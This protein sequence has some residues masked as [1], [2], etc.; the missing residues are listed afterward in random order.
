MELRNTYVLQG[1]AGFARGELDNVAVADDAVTLER[2]GG[3][4]VLYGCYTSPPVN[5]PGFNQM[6]VSWNADTPAGTVVEAQARVLQNGEWSG[7]ASFGKWSP[8][9]RRAGV[10]QGRGEAGG[11]PAV[12][13]DLLT[14]QG[15]AATQVQLRVYLY[16]DDEK[17]TPAVWLLAASV[18]PAGWQPQAGR[19][20]DRALYAPA[21]SQITRDP[22][23]GPSMDLPVA[24]ASLMNRWG[25]DVLPEE[26]AHMMYDEA[27]GSC[28]NRAFAAAAAG[29][30]GFEAYTAYM[31]LAALRQEVRAGHSA[32]IQLA[33]AHTPQLAEE[34]GLPLLHG[35][36]GT[37]R[38]MAV[39]R[40]FALAPGGQGEV[41]LLNDPLAQADGEA[42]CQVP[43]EE[44]LHCWDNA[45][46]AV[47]RKRRDG[48]AARPLQMV[49]RLEPLGPVGQYR[50]EQQGQPW[51]L[52][53]AAGES[54]RPAYTLAYT[55]QEGAVHATTAHKAFHYLQPGP[56][57]AVCLP[58]ELFSAGGR[59][60]VYAID[61]QGNLVV[62]ELKA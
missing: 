14:V 32:A 5:M 57:G 20:I 54:G 29:C 60:T 52:L 27:L 26:M 16:T 12:Q 24:V 21:Y 59:I 30:C 3:R 45:A 55:V 19:Q 1:T 56:G 44:L 22:A 9:L 35:V 41:A 17:A 39:V 61:W 34:T 62:A 38:R 46:L 36:R 28:H 11:A 42:E 53:P 18:R 6:T 49:G 10:C 15:A 13:G 8:F 43:L 40:G 58:P 23:F 2:V 31:D 51:P 7:W 4:Y 25:A 48:G 33:C 50:I 37:G 47:H